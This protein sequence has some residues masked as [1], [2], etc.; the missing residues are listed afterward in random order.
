MDYA[1]ILKVIKIENPDLSHR[2]AMKKASEQFQKFKKLEKDGG[3]IKPP[4]PDAPVIE[5]TPEEKGLIP[6]ER[7]ISA[8][9]QIREVGPDV[10]SVSRLG[11]EAIP[12][13][14]LIKHGKSGVNTMVTWED[15]AGN[16]IPV[17]GGYFYIYI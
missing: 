12:T 1:G 4:V 11:R 7:L 17:G 9:K 13:G 14:Q 5:A 6:V 3:L 15:M 8:E 16:R 2:E 10:N